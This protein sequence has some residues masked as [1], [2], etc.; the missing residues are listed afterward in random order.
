MTNPVRANY[1]R[2]HSPQLE[3][4]LHLKMRLTKCVKGV[5]ENRPQGVRYKN[6]GEKLIQELEEKKLMADLLDSYLP[7]SNSGDLGFRG[8]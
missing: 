5:F 8:G 4:G 6:I 7:F 3:D 2:P 1:A